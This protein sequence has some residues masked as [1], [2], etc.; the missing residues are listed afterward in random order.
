MMALIVAAVPMAAR[1]RISRD[2]ADLPSEAR[3]MLNQYFKGEKI[4]HI[5][6]E[7]HT[8]GGNEYDVILDNGNEIEFDSNGS[9]TDVDCGMQAVPNDLILKPIREYVN[10]VFKGQKIVKIEK[11]RNKYEIELRD[12]TDLEFDRAGKFLRIDD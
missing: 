5:K 1:D 3:A 6:I 9:W 7:S 10:N 12:G 8:F 2:A 11:K 4:S